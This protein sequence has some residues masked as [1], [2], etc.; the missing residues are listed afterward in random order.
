MSAILADN[1]L[2][3]ALDVV[4]ALPSERKRTVIVEGEF[5]STRAAA[6]GSRG[7]ADPRAQPPDSPERA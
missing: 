4:D 3:Q 7:R 5:Y 2:Y 1:R 6:R